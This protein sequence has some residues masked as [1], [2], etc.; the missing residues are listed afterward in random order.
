MQET[1]GSISAN[2]RHRW[3]TADKLWWCQSNGAAVMAV[4]HS[5]G[6]SFHRAL[7]PLLCSRGHRLLRRRARRR[8]KKQWREGPANQRRGDGA[9]VCDACEVW[10]PAPTWI[11][12]SG[13]TEGPGRSLGRPRDATVEVRFRLLCCHLVGI[14]EKR[15]TS[16]HGGLQ[17]VQEREKK[18]KP[19]CLAHYNMN[20]VKMCHYYFMTK[21]ISSDFVN[22]NANLG[23]F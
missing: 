18:S 14:W 7:R 9:L 1:P 19:N 13:R 5:Q 6:R 21:Y 17:L 15:S 16:S 20:W 12:S 8:K 11:H 2:I 10:A 23:T 3:A 4:Y 22:Y